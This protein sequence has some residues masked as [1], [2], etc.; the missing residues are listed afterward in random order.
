MLHQHQP[1]L[2][3]MGR[4][5]TLACVLLV[6]AACQGYSSAKASVLR[7]P[8]VPG[9]VVEVEPKTHLNRVISC[10]SENMDDLTVNLTQ[11]ETLRQGSD[12]VYKSAAVVLDSKRAGSSVARHSREE[13]FGFCLH[14]ATQENWSDLDASKFSV[15]V[16]VSAVAPLSSGIAAWETQTVISPKGASAATINLRYDF[17][18]VDA[19][20]EVLRSQHASI[21]ALDRLAKLLV[22]QSRK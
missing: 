3:S 12:I 22:K 21:P 5:L 14:K 19:V 15:D 16:H 20:I 8:D 4:C 2:L 1:R 6:G 17:V 9:S 13:S 10:L 18:R 11:G 7:E